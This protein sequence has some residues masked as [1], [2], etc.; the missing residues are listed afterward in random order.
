MNFVSIEVLSLSCKALMGDYLLVWSFSF[1]SLGIPMRYKNIFTVF[2]LNTHHYFVS[3][4]ANIHSSGTCCS[5]YPTFSVRA[6]LLV[7]PQK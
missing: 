6:I 3:I 1:R 7:L 2:V 5:N 4:N